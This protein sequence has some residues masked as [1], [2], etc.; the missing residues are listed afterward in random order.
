SA[1]RALSPTA[2]TL[3]GVVAA[4]GRVAISFLLAAGDRKAGKGTYSSHLFEPAR[5]SA[6]VWLQERCVHRQRPR[7][8]AR[9]AS[10]RPLDPDHLRLV[11]ERPVLRDAFHRPAHCSFGGLVGNKDHGL[12]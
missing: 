12:V 1:S 11:D 3:T 8:D 5:E 4:K 7:D 6:Q 9:G 10:G 2:A